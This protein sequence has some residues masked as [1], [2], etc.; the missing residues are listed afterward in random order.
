MFVCLN[1]KR[2]Y[3][4]EGT[5][6]HCPKCGGLF[7]MSQPLRFN[8]AQV[9]D[10][11]PRIWHYRHTFRLPPSTQS[12]S[13]GEGATPLTWAEVSGRRV[14][15]KDETRNPTGSFKDRGVPLMVA[16]LRSRGVTEAIEYSSGNAGASF[17]AYAAQAGIRATVYVPAS[18][19]DFKRERIRAYGAE[20]REMDGQHSQVAETVKELADTGATYASHA[21][22]PFL[23]PGYATIAYEIFENLGVAPSAVITPAGQGGLFLGLY[24]GFEALQRAGLITTLPQIIG[25]Q[26]RACAPLWVMSTVGFSGMGFVTEGQT[27]AEGVRVRYPLRAGEIRQVV[28]TGYGS[29]V[30]VEEGDI[31]RGRDELAR[32]GLYV[33]LTSAIVWA[34][35]EEMLQQ[36]ADPLVVLLTGA[37]ARTA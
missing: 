25:V 37:A 13:L 22:L 31:L 23:I 5:P 34:A 7:G 6:Y 3:P 10:S 4:E 29:F 20:L 33:E 36:F 30:S 35:L 28:D 15:F 32:R 8:P 27:L 24:R 26:A 9:D 2:P 19:S 16:F 1:C 11:Q 21:Y 14:A 12:V 17:A 18:T